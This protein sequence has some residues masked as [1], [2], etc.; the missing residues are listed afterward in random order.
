MKRFVDSTKFSSYFQTSSRSERLKLISKWKED[1]KSLPDKLLQDLFRIQISPQERLALIEAS[2]PIDPAQYETW[3]FKHLLTWPQE[4]AV[5]ALRSWASNTHKES[6]ERLLPVIKLPGLPQRISYTIL[7]ISSEF[8]GKSITKAIL[9]TN[10]WEDFSPAYHGLLFDRCVD[11]S[12]SSPRVLALALKKL[13]ENSN[14]AHSDDKCLISAGLFLIRFGKSSSV[15]DIC[16]KAPDCGWKA[17][18][19]LAVKAHATRKKT[20]DLHAKKLAKSEFNAAD[21]SRDLP[22]WARE[23][24]DPLFLQKVIGQLDPKV[25][26][27]EIFLAGVDETT[28]KVA[29]SECVKTCSTDVMDSVKR[30]LGEPV[31]QKKGM[32]KLSCELPYTGTSQDIFFTELSGQKTSDEHKPRDFWEHLLMTWKSR[33][34]LLL[35]PLTVEARKQ[36]G[37][38]TICY[39]MTLGR[40]VGSDDA[41]L[42]LMDHVR[43]NEEDVLRAIVS[44]LGQINS[45]RSL[46]ELI[47]VLTRPNATLLV[48]QDAVAI[49]AKKDL[50]GLQKELHAAVRDLRV[51]PDSSSPIAEI[52]ESLE[53]LI[54]IKEAEVAPIKGNGTTETLDD[55]SLDTELRSMIPQY[56]ELSSEVRRALRTALFFNHSIAGNET[57]NA[58][59]LSPLI[60]MQYK[61]MELLFR[62]F[63]EDPVSQALYRGDIPRK[64]DVIGYARPIPFKMDE[65]EHYV[66]SLP[67]VREIPFFSKFKMRKMLRAICQFEP[68]KRFT[69]DGLKAFGLFFLCFSRLQCRFGLAGLVPIGAKSDLDLAQFAKELHIFQDFRNRA[70]HEGFHPEASN[71]ILGIWKITANIVKWA[72]QIREAMKGL[73]VTPP[74]IGKRA[75]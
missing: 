7:D 59:D 73:P 52:R 56:Q 35:Q 38:S 55:V 68:G 29:A 65:F 37:L 72:F 18:L 14:H 2:A 3:I 33:N 66:A 6:W 67:V 51:P 39:I 15:L 27:A 25:T 60:D 70:A 44:A 19:H 63:F 11:Y 50:S 10:G 46:L 32:P 42:K 34:P 40:L 1:N 62:E 31:N 8:A 22:P 21:Y 71:D 75:S 64:L 4:V 36:S 54:T 48:Q 12:C 45:P 58:I 30:W 13:E 53:S 57:S 43:T 49:L 24:I 41:V 61:A 26:S 74:T 17:L 69:L 16:A 20:E 23:S 28:I 5:V 47:S 9:E